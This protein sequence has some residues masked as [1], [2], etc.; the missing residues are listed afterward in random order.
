MYN[1]ESVDYLNHGAPTMA[2]YTGLICTVI[3]IMRISKLFLHT[4]HINIG[5]TKSNM[6]IV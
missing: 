2:V 5:V 4:F 3:L 6:Q 1:S